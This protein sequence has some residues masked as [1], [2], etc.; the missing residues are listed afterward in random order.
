[1]NMI[2]FASVY[3]CIEK[4]STKKM[5]RLGLHM[6]ITFYCLSIYWNE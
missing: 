5:V 6:F 4:G 1:M 3:S 2:I